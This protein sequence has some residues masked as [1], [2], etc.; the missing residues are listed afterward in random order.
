MSVCI[1]ILCA[2]PSGSSPNHSR[3]R[4]EMRR[5]HAR[6]LEG[7]ERG[8]EKDDQREGGHLPD[9]KVEVHDGIYCAVATDGGGRRWRSEN[10]GEEETA[11]HEY[12]NVCYCESA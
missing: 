11:Q 8:R 9:H 7:D 6:G 3:G 12:V 1:D 5:Q 4:D 2:Q 10:E